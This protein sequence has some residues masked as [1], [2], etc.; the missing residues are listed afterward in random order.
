MLLGVRSDGAY[1]SA[2]RSRRIGR[3]GMALDVR[4]PHHLTFL[5][6]G[7][8]HEV[9]TTATTVRSAMA[10]A[11]VDAARAGPRVRRP[12]RRALRRAGRRPHPGRRQAGRRGAPDQVRHREAQDERPLPG[13]H[14]DRQ[15]GQGRHR[16]ADLPRDLP[17][18]Q[19]RLPQARQQPGHREAGDRGAAGRHQEDAGQ[20]TGRRRPQLG[21]AGQLR[22]GRQP[23]GLQ[24][25]RPLLRA[26]PVHGEHLA[27][28]G[29]RRA[30]RPTPARPSRPT[31]RRSS[32]TAA[33]PAS[34]R[35][36]ATTCSADGDRRRRRGPRCSGRPR[37][38]SSPPG[39][40][41]AR[42]RRSGR[43]S[44]ST[45]TPCAGSCAPQSCAPTTTSSR[46]G[47]AS[48]R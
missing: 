4:M 43:T 39:S 23:P 40:A 21:R 47:R 14:Q 8:R 24:L 36:A 33:V 12:L 11:G 27:R 25:G 2:S 9:T 32:T 35:S 13:H 5:A 19:A 3:G 37:C 29:R 38:A 17:R 44:S 28:R 41:S 22:V 7:T 42:P 30:C 34:G 20:R 1:V 15:A 31:G 10:E 16:G 48:A 26:L 45:P 18:R 46:S 6:D